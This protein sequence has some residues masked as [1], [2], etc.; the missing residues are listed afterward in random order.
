MQNSIK[1][2]SSDL[3]KAY[4]G[5][6]EVAKIYLGS[7]LLYS[8]TTPTE[9]LATPQ[10]VS[11][12]GTVV[13]WNS[14]T[15][16]TSYAVYV[17]YSLYATTASN[18]IELTAYAKWTTLNVG[19]HAVTIV[20]QASGYET[21][22]Q[23][24]AVAVAKT[25]TP[26]ATNDQQTMADVTSGALAFGIINHDY[27]NELLE[28][29][30][31]LEFS[32]SVHNSLTEYNFN[33]TTAGGETETVDVAQMILNFFCCIMQK[34]YSKLEGIQAVLDEAIADGTFD[35]IIESNELGTQIAEWI[36][37]WIAAATTAGTYTELAYQEFISTESD[38]G[39]ETLKDKMNNDATFLAA[40]EE[41]KAL[42]A[43]KLG[44]T[45]EQ[46]TSGNW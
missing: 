40:R 25:E 37:E 46:L 15:N 6:N 13:T 10:N 28:S 22:D 14:V 26:S 32:D 17:D 1:I 18:A 4:Y 21:S 35:Q 19:V 31:T 2:G 23:S 45:V 30:D 41:F 34:G 43:E 12:T 20:A 44:I 16:A 39:N 27:N 3:D 11:A 8:A 7:V 29:F 9:K 36:N 38:T 42:I 24:E 33:R 5:S